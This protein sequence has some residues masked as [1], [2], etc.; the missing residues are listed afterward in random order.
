MCKRTQKEIE[1]NIFDELEERIKELSIRLEKLEKQNKEESE[2][3]VSS[4]KTLK[5]EI[6]GILDRLN[7]LEKQN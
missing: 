3:D 5:R 6:Q 7:N 4:K 2:I 1:K